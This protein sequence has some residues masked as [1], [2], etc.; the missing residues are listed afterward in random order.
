MLEATAGE[1][2]ALAERAFLTRFALRNN[3]EASDVSITA[4]HN[5]VLGNRAVEALKKN[6]FDARYFGTRDEATQFVLSLIK[7]GDKVGTGGSMTLTELGLH[8]KVKQKGAV[9]LDH[10]DPSLSPEQKMEIRR[11]QLVCDV[12]LSGTN[13]VTLDGWLLNVDGTGNRVAAMTFGPKKVVIVV[14]T[15]KITEDLDAAL[16]RIRLKASPMNNKRLSLPNPCATTGVCEECEG[17]TRICNIYSVLR[18][19]PSATDISVVVI[20]EDLGY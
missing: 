7:S 8:D 10:S 6:K 19:K 3:E 4:W 14:G 15:N 2:F 16:D 1:V 13:A 11:Q 9:L 5:E 12:F 18:R 17:N 20:G